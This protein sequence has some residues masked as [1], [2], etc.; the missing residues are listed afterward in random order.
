MKWDVNMMKNIVGMPY[1]LA[2]TDK[3]FAEM[4]AREDMPSHVP[5][6]PEI[7]IKTRRLYIK[8]ADIDKFGFSNGCP[9]CNAIRR[10]R[11]PV[12][13]SEACRERIE[14]MLNQNP[15]GA[16]RIAKRKQAIDTAVAEAGEMHME[17]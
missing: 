4:T 9:G 8:K 6:P 10:H 14:T 1:D 11:A 5:E 15:D 17:R 16:D 12:N 3:V 2:S 7:E 13:H